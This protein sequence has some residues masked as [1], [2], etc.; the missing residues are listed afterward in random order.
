MKTTLEKPVAN[1][2]TPSA[3]KSFPLNYKPQ[4]HEQEIRRF[5]SQFHMGKLDRLSRLGDTLNAKVLVMCFLNRTG[6]NLLAEALCATGQVGFAVEYFHHAEVRERSERFRLTSLNDYVCSLADTLGE[7]QTT[8]S[9][10]LSWD[11]LYYL[12]QEDI[13]PGFFRDP[14]F[15]YLTRK[16]LAA[17]AL[18][19]LTAKATGRWK[20]YLEKKVLQDQ[21]ESEITDAMISQSMARLENCQ[22]RFEDYF[23]VMQIEPLR[24]YYEDLDTDLETQVRRVMNAM[25]L[26]LDDDWQLDHTRIRVKKQRNKD[27]EERLAVFR[28]NLQED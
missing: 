20:S 4:V 15:V 24:I 6:S 28:R 19:F 12:T 18:S 3:H 11:Q 9:I 17:Q 14:V 1:K 22:T 2:F 27:S 8:L 5:Y 21:A 16:D 10:R 23:R 13:I 7:A 25:K 26:P